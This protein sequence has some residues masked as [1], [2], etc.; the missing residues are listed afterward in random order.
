MNNTALVDQIA[1]AAAQVALEYL[2]REKL[3]R[4]KVKRDQRLR[5][6][7]LLLKNYRSFV[8]HCDELQDRLTAIQ[9]AETLNELHSEEYAIDSISRSKKRTI[10]MTRFI[11]QMVEVYGKMCES[12]RTPE[13][14]RRYK[15]IHTL[16]ISEEKMTPEQLS[17]IHQ[18]DT[19]TVY[20]DVNNASKTL[21]I[22]IFGVD[23]IQ[24]D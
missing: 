16:Y 24:F 23:G 17:E 13:D 10:V 12:S 15:V 21:A 7:K 20:K 4:Q 8:A 3:R 14:M 5:N 19:R 2:D 9:E 18:I 6:T 1:K 22:L 11:Q